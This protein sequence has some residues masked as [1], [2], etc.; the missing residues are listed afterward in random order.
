[1]APTGHAATQSL[2]STH[3]LYSTGSLAVETSP[4]TRM[5]PRLMKLPKTGWITQRWSPIWPMPAAMAI[6]L[7]ETTQIRPG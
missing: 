5:V 3:G 7:C 1:M 2:Q 4:A 6:G